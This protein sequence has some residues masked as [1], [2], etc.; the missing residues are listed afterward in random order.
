MATKK[1]GFFARLFFQDPEK[2]KKTRTP[3]IPDLGADLLTLEASRAAS[4]AIDTAETRAAFC[5]QCGTKNE[6][7]GKFCIKCGSKMA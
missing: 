6:A 4:A 3:E 2:Y 1:R 7:L 5:T